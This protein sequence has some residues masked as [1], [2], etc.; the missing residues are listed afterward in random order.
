MIRV[1]HKAFDM[2][3]YLAKEPRRPRKLNEVSGHLK[4]NAGTCANILK[5]MVQRK[6]VDQAN[7]R[8]GYLLGP[9]I[10][11][12]SRL[13][14]YRGDLI[15]AAEPLMA[16]LVKRV[17]ETVLLVILR[18]RERFIIIQ[19]DGNQNVQ[20]GRDLFLQGQIY[21]TATGRLLLAYSDKKVFNDF[22]AENGLPGSVWP[23]ASSQSKLESALETIRRRGWVSYKASGDVIGIAY[24]ILESNNVVAALGLFLPAFRFKGAHKTAV[25]KGMSATS[26][27]ISERLSVK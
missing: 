17:N 1:I 14:A 25:M 3:E 6:Y 16:D 13:S 22:V 23:E 24:P 9:M 12:L 10:Y 27:A 11:Y 20:V 5:T 2:L 26:S 4:M 15:L 21:Q 7:V 18:G 19:I 8:G